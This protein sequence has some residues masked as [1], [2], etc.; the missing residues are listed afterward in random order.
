MSGKK[1]S[2]RPTDS[3]SEAPSYVR[4]PK[5]LLP[6]DSA[7][8]A[9]KHLEQQRLR[10]R[11][12]LG[13]EEELPDAPAPSSRPVQR[14]LAHLP[15]HALPTPA[16]S[17][18]DIDT[19]DEEAETMSFDLTFTGKARDVDTFVAKIRAHITATP[20][21]RGAAAA[22]FV[23]TKL[24]GTAWEWFQTAKSTE[25]AI[26][27]DH[28]ALLRAISGKFAW[29]EIAK[30]TRAAARI[31]TCQQGRRSVTSYEVEFNTLARELGYSDDQKIQA[32]TAGLSYRIRSILLTRGQVFTSY[33]KLVEKTTTFD[34]EILADK[35][36]HLSVGTGRQR[37]QGQSSTKKCYKCGKFG[38]VKRDCK[39]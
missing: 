8:K 14:F 22:A 13:T 33:D 12:S 34:E 3:Q 30:K 29:D 21:L 35:L 2:R 20:K 25:S 38:H 36:S 37:K 23:Q 28:E 7:S 19:S 15:S 27:T 10:F 24:E 32:F 9:R 5:S 1:P 11:E 31:K 6:E 4:E 16:S 17:Q 26:D 18:Y 39:T